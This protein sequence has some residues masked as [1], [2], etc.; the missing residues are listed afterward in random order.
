MDKSAW[1]ISLTIFALVGIIV[2]LVLAS[3]GSNSSSYSSNQDSR[4]LPN[5]ANNPVRMVNGVQEVDLQATIQGYNYNEIQ[6]KAGIPVKLLFTAQQNI[7]CGS[8]LLMRDFNVRLQS[9][10]E[11]ES[12]EFTPSTKGIFAFNCPMNMYRGRLIVE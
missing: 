5:Y 10:G 1:L 9:N 3:S 7:G 8:V 2:Y 4:S 11:T 12:A 6:V